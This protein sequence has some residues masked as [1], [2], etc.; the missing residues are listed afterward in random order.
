MGLGLSSK[1]KV[2]NRQEFDGSMEIDVRGK[3]SIV[4]QKFAENIF[5]SI[6]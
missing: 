3:K 6:V 1:I 5:V 4:S 2:I